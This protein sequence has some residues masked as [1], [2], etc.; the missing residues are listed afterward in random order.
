MVRLRC[1]NLS[2]LDGKIGL[3]MEC[4]EVNCAVSLRKSRYAQSN[5]EVV[6]EKI[7]LSIVCDYCE[8]DCNGKFCSACMTARYCDMT[9]QD[10][11]RSTAK[12]FEALKMLKKNVC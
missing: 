2:D 7:L 11:D 10:L 3:I 6:I 8:I 12:S 9:C 1:P 5:Q 4:D